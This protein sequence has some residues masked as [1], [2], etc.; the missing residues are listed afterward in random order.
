[1][2]STDFTLRPVGVVRTRFEDLPST[3]TQASLQRDDEGLLEL[4]PRYQDGLDGLSGFSHAWLVSWLGQASDLEFTPALRQVP[5]PL[6]DQQREVGVFAT[7]SPLRPNPVGLSLVRILGV[8]GTVIR[9]GGV[10]LLDGTPILDIKPYIPSI[11]VPD[12]ATRQ[13]WLDDVTG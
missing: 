13:G 3:P 10:D 2:A 7:R 11:D 9:F 5:N 12:E 4:D 1:M 6:R 8:E